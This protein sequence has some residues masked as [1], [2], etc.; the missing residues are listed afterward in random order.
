MSASRYKYFDPQDAAR[1]G[2]LGFVARQPVEGS[3][4]GL[5]RS[6]HRGF[7]VEFA[8]HREYVPGDDLRYLD[9]SAWAR[10]DRYYIKRYEQETNLRTT[11][12]LDSSGSMDYAGNGT[13]KFEYA[14]RLTSL[15]AYMLVRQLDKVGLVT[16]DDEPRI[17]LP[18]AATPQHLDRI[19][20]QLESIKPAG[21]TRLSRSL[22]RV[23]EKIGRRGLLVL[24]SDL[25]DEPSDVLKALRH[26]QHYRH[27][28]IVLH[29]L[30]PAELALPFNRVTTFVDRETRQ[31]IQI[32]PKVVRQEY[33]R[34]IE[35]FIAAYRRG[36]GEL[37]IDY[38]LASTGE[39]FTDVLREF[40]A[41]VAGHR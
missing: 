19:F 36:C 39:R 32:D 13:T 24:I 18:P 4:S 12:L 23:A 29:V 6:P 33:R 35:G 10:T 8:D 20:T 25:Y 30:D 7:S 9:W 15:L 41:T 1:L 38:R 26:I 2:N 11:I 16:F 40:L 34:Q 37:S 3:V 21:K 28:I 22:H 5:H 31:R 14:C 17:T 27:Q